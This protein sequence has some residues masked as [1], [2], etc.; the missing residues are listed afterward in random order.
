MQKCQDFKN[1]YEHGIKSIMLT[2]PWGLQY[3][4]DYTKS[5]SLLSVEPTSCDSLPSKA[6]LFLSFETL[7]KNG[8]IEKGQFLM[9]LDLESDKSFIVNLE[10]NHP[11]ITI[12]SPTLVSFFL[13]YSFSLLAFS[14]RFQHFVSLFIIHQLVHSNW[15]PKLFPPSS[16][17]RILL[18]QSCLC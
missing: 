13:S 3:P 15:I 17:K 10:N 18:L 11:L 1:L 4:L 16:F 6:H 8:I 7:Q 12:F 2:N 9:T 5:V 14:S